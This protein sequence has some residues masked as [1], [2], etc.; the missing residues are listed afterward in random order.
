MDA[1]SEKI[2]NHLD[3]MKY[4]DEQRREKN[5]QILN[6]RIREIG[7]SKNDKLIK[8]HVTSLHEQSW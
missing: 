4:L 3:K 8:Q 1:L 5:L 2:K 6:S 7:E